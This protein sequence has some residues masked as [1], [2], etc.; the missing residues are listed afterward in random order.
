MF[1]QDRGS[2]FPMGSKHLEL[3]FKVFP[4]EARLTTKESRGVASVV[5]GR[6]L[7]TGDFQAL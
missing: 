6:L 3:A 5:W 7:E 1:R 4:G 2:C